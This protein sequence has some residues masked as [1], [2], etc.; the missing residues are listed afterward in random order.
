MTEQYISRTLEATL[1]EAWR[2]FPVLAVTGPRQSGKSTLIRHLFPDAVSFS[3]KDVHVCAYALNDPVAFLS[4]TEAPLFIDEI[5]MAPVLLEYIQGIVDRNPARKF[6]LSG[7]S[8]FE[9][10]K[11]LSESLAGR[12]GVF[13]L[14]PMSFSETVE[15]TSRKELDAML[16]DG[17]YPAI[18]AGK[19]VARLYYPSYV[20]TYLERDVRDLLNIKDMMLFMRFMKLCAAR[21]GSLFNASELSS[22]V[23]VD[24]KTI[25]SWLSVLQASYV[26]YLLP[27]YYENVSKR[28]VKS[29]KLYFCDS[30]LACHLLDI[31]SAA[32]LSRDKMRG[33]IFENFVVMEAVKH[34]MHAGRDGGVYFYRDSNKNEVDLL[35][36]EE[37]VITAV[38]VKSSQ[39][40]SPAF[41][42]T[43]KKLP[44][45]LQTPVKRRVVVYAGDFE[46]AMGQVEVLNYKHFAF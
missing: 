27:P 33:N 36:K 37:G 18:C 13:E 8:N 42:T 44:Q 22:E 26:V 31:E 21:V 35:L 32:Q 41:E 6:I 16:F 38:E 45:W 46:N 1:L 5:Q 17:F 43:L 28:L 19:H 24:N 30:G 15:E 29:P 4:Q 2:Y 39:T 40:Y 3:L 23:G 7:S 25:A 14:L 34:R 12:C 20:K 9:L 11:G 10:M